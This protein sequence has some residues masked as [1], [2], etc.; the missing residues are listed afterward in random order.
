M[1]LP[2]ESSNP[3]S[4]K[5]APK[6]GGKTDTPVGISEWPS[7]SH[8]LLGPAW[9]RLLQAMLLPLWRAC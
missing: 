2:L 1:K 4:P 7:S 6:A 8:P 5:A 9:H 3:H